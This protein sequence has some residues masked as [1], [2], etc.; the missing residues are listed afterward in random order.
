MPKN[1]N[2]TKKAGQ[3]LIWQQVPKFKNI[4]LFFKKIKI[5]ISQLT[6]KI[7]LKQRNLIRRQ[8]LTVHSQI[9]HH[10]FIRKYESFLMTFI[11][12]ISQFYD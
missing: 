4:K 1:I 11:I 5:C 2:K 12:E 6:A 8:C 3:M 7:L 10:F 9:W